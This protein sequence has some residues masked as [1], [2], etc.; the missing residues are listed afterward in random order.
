MQLLI[1]EGDGKKDCADGS[2]EINCCKLC[3]LR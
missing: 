1:V 3:Y 2:D